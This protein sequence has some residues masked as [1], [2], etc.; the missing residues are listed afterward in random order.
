MGLFQNK[1]L[2][3]AENR[4]TT[5]LANEN[6]LTCLNHVILNTYLYIVGLNFMG[7]MWKVG[8]MNSIL[9]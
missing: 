4:M 8:G 1:E 5:N 2:L 3:D 6:P 9:C 7:E